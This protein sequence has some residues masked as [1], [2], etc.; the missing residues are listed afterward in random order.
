[1]READEPV[2]VGGNAE[3]T[4]A[5]MRA[6]FEHDRDYVKYRSE[7]ERLTERLGDDPFAVP[8]RTPDLI[9]AV[10]RALAGD[11]PQHD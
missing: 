4:P 11:A 5:A 10:E 6:W 2:E 3:I 1:V 7:V 9:A 8:P